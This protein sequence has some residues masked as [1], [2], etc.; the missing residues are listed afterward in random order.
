MTNSLTKRIG[1]LEARTPCNDEASD[2][3]PTDYAALRRALWERAAHPT[4]APVQPASPS[5]VAG[6]LHW[7]RKIAET[8]ARAASMPPPDEPGKTNYQALRIMAA[9]KAGGAAHHALRGAELEVLTEAGFD[10]L[11]LDQLKAEH[12]RY[13][14]I[15]WQ[16]H[17]DNLPAE[18]QSVIDSALASAAP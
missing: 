9:Q 3:D 17:G 14:G 8:A 5:G 13:E 12:T 10:R 1:A 6:V 18:A 15:P 4:L 2:Q 16:W 7:R 11:V